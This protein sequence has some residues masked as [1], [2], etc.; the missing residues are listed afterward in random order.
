MKRKPRRERRQQ[1]E[2]RTSHAR[3]G[4]S[5]VETIVAVVLLSFAIL[6]V[7]GTGT[8]VL[9][10]MG[11]AR[12]DLQLW[13][14]LQTVADSL[15]SVGIGSVGA[16]NRTIAGYSFTWTV[17]STTNAYDMIVL[18]GSSSGTHAVADSMVIWIN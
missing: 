10:Q 1:R 13:A 11:R 17:D 4:F 2:L 6:G 18:R 14:G 16:G 7:T 3:G 8:A 15:R 5:L 9:K 12:S